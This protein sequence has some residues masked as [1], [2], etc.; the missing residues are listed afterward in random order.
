MFSNI[1]CIF[2]MNQLAW[3]TNLVSFIF[4]PVPK[5]TPW[6]KWQA[7]MCNGRYCRESTA[8]FEAHAAIPPFWAWWNT[9]GS[10]AQ[11]QDMSQLWILFWVRDVALDCGVINFRIE[12]ELKRLFLGHLRLFVPKTQTIQIWTAAVDVNAADFA[13]LRIGFH[14]WSLPKWH[15]RAYSRTRSASTMYIANWKCQTCSFRRE[16]NWNGLLRSWNR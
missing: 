10:K 9:T 1:L 16:C 14:L 8:P 6:H 12:F 5:R 4:S 15:G 13:T 2:W 7:T 11:V 3:I